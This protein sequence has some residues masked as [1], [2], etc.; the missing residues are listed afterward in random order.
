MFET[1]LNAAAEDLWRE[2]GVL[3]ALAVLVPEQHSV[4]L[5]E[6]IADAEG[7]VPPMIDSFLESLLLRAPE[8]VG[9]RAVEIVERLL[10]H[11]YRVQR[12]VGEAGP[13]LVR[14]RPSPSTP[15][16]YTATSLPV[17]SPTATPRGRSGSSIPSTTSTTR[18]S[19]G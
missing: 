6:I 15:P 7:A 4:E 14:S 3:G 19:N 2:L 1:W 17:H 11:P 10:T 9:P 8:H 13:G 16:G 12:D 18:R 5:A